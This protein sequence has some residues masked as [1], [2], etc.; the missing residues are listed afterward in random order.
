MSKYIDLETKPKPLAE[1]EA[2]MP[3]F[4]AA[5]NIKD[6]AKI[7]A[8][9]AK[10]QAAFIEKAAL[11]PFTGTIQA[12]GFYDEETEEY[13]AG[14]DCLCLSEKFMIQELWAR[15]ADHGAMTTDV[16]GWNLNNFDLPFLIKRSWANR[17]KIPPTAL[18]NYR[19]R[20][21]LNA[22]YKDLMQHWCIGSDERYAS[23]NGALAHL[24]MPLKVDLDGKLPYDIL[25]SEPQL[26]HDYLR[27]DVMALVEINKVVGL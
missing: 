18:E 7:A 20:S 3:K 8:D 11:S 23:L 25:E 27:Q 12:Y 16:I 4:E 5:K 2:I 13:N 17:V 26:F 10:K 15:I 19:G 21:F 1:L 24:G 9:I 22:R 14:D 6:P